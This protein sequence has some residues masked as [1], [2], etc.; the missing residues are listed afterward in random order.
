[1]GLAVGRDRGP[2]DRL[3][4][5][6]PITVAVKRRQ[7]LLHVRDP[8][9]RRHFLI[10]LHG[11]PGLEQADHLQNRFLPPP[12]RG[13]D[14]PP[15]AAARLATGAE[16]RDVAAAPTGDRLRQGAFHDIARDRRGLRR[17]LNRRV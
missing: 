7:G 16:L 6:Q 15:G 2:G 3:A 11:R 10:H 8:E 12:I 1:M 17:D 13:F 9:R 4:V 5:E 14:A